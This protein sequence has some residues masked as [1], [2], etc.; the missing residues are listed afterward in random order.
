M[1]F[2][3]TVKGIALIGTLSLFAV[4]CREPSDKLD[5][6]IG[7]L[8]MNQSSPTARI[9][10]NITASSTWPSGALMTGAVF[11]QPGVT[12]TVKAG[13]TI[14]ADAG[15]SL[16]ILP[17]A[18][19][20]AIGSAASPIVFTS[21]KVSGQRARE[22]WGGI[23]LI[24]NATSNL[25]AVKT[26]EGSTPQ[27][28]GNGTNDADS[29]GS[30]KYVR[31]EYAG[32]KVGTANE[33]NC[34]SSY[35][36]GS[37]T[38]LDHVQCHMSADDS[39]EFWGG[40]VTGKY[41]LSTGADDDDFDFDEGYH[42]KMQYILGYKYEI[43]SSEADPRGFEHNGACGSAGCVTPNGF[44]GFADY[45]TVKIANFTL[46][47]STAAG[48][49]VDNKSSTQNGMHL[50]F[51]MKGTYTH[52]L[53]FGFGGTGKS[54]NCT[55][56]EAAP[57]ASAAASASLFHIRTTTGVATA[58]NSCTFDAT[59]TADLPNFATV[60][61]TAPTVTAENTSL[62]HAN[63]VAAANVTAVIPADAFFTADTGYGAVTATSGNWLSGWT[64]Y[65]Q[66]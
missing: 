40:A 38:V 32:N 54:I 33:L 50:R 57:F 23:V 22:D 36:V 9:S 25:A 3:N 15:S 53:V 18:R 48:G 6:S 41:L 52:G 62:V 55:T 56:A 30:L 49:N 34:L 31:I 44:G 64:Y 24:G 37:G 11:I 66:N 35:T 29:S 42:G 14:Y 60:I 12:V 28:Y 1:N 17:G 7:L 19:L 58:A 2:L 16:F 63:L 51:G 8:L 20:N 59:V 21:A 39:F 5:P 43:V 61:T 4:N 65:K 45:S 27:N 13:S 10:G 46:I 26:T 47:G